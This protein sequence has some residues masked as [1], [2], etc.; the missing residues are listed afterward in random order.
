M[1]KSL[2]LTFFF[3]STA[4]YSQYT[5]E[6]IW[7]DQENKEID[8]RKIEEQKSITLRDDIILYDFNEKTGV[9][10]NKHFTGTDV[11][12][13]GI[14]YFTGQRVRDLG[15]FRSLEASYSHRLKELWL[16]GFIAKM[17]AQ[18]EDITENKAGESKPDDLGES[19][20]NFG[21]GIEYRF[22]FFHHWFETEHFFQSVNAYL[23]YS[24]LSEEAANTSSNSLD[25]DGYGLRTDYGIHYRASSSLHYGLK[26]SYNLA[27]LEREAEFATEASNDLRL[28]LAWLSFGFDIG[29]Y[30]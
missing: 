16:S 1:I 25:Y 11:G 10:D 2:A 4:S 21:F 3:I 12:R 9:K 24:L 7:E 22:K 28:Q 27:W 19:L 6:T 5:D 15:S 26:L 17:D 18:F 20:L 13:F 23:T 29:Y 14:S 8:F 30:F